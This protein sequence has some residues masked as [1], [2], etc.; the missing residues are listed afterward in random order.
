MV[1]LPASPFRA[2]EMAP[3]MIGVLAVIGLSLVADV[4]IGAVPFRTDDPSWRFQVAGQI[5]NTAPQLAL[6]LMLALGVGLYAE[7]FGVLKWGAIACLVLAALLA[8]LLPFFALDFLTV[9]HLQNQSRL[10]GFLRM[11]LRLAGIAG[12]LMLGLVWAGI[13]GVVVA[14]SAL[15][16]GEPTEG[17]GIVIGQPQG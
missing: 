6:L 11:G 4:V 2:H 16:L 15:P 14:R 5:L 7:R 17:P 1:N 13:R 3:A 9:R 12:L 10:S 8:L